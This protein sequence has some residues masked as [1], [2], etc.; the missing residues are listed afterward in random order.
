V[1]EVLASVQEHPHGATVTQEE[2]ESYCKNAAFIKLIP[3]VESS[4]ESLKKLAGIPYF[5]LQK[6]YIDWM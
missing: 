3:V 6:A 4:V 5:L 1:A 2:V